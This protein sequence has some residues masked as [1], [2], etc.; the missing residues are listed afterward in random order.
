M[1]VFTSIYS[2]GFFTALGDGVTSAIISFLRTTVF[3]AAAVLLLPLI[4]KIDGV[5]MPLVAAEFM[6]MALSLAFLVGKK[7]RYHY[8]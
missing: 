3:Q 1:M 2:S 5:W 7:N 6:V 4:W 8:L